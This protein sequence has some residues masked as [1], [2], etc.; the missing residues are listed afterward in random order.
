MISDYYDFI[1]FLG[2]LLAASGIVYFFFLRS[3]QDIFISEEEIS[4]LAALEQINSLKI[5]FPKISISV[6]LLTVII[7]G[8]LLNQILMWKMNS[9]YF[10]KPFSI[11]VNITRKNV[12]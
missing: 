10:T 12:K 3:L 2:G 7:G 8:F 1:I 4:K 11:S 6:I 9:S 5:S